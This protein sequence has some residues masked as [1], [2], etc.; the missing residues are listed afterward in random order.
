M[1]SYQ[2]TSTYICWHHASYNILW[3]IHQFSF[4]LAPTCNLNL[5]MKKNQSYSNWWTLYKIAGLCSST[6][7][8]WLE[9]KKDWR[10]QPFLITRTKYLK[11]MAQQSFMAS[12]KQALGRKAARDA[13]QELP[14]GPTASTGSHLLTAHWARSTSEL[15]QWRAQHS[16]IQS[17]LLES[18]NLV[19]LAS[20]VNWQKCLS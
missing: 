9:T 17:P 11:G 1:F 2:T 5:T 13:L 8:G 19:K 6:V 15:I 12:W 20:K 16:M 4:I 7:S 3:R 14:P 10:I 18:L